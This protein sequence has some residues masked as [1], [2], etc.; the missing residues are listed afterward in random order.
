MFRL[1]QNRLLIREVE[2]GQV[3]A[4]GASKTQNLPE[5][6]CC[7]PGCLQPPDLGEVAGRVQNKRSEGLGR[8]LGG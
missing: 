1:Q 4:N 6:E 3:G 5:L 8:W 7:A 2:K